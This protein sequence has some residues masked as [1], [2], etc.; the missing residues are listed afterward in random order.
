MKIKLNEPERKTLG[1]TWQLTCR[2]EADSYAHL[3][4]QN[5]QHHGS[6]FTVPKRFTVFFLFPK[7]AR[8]RALCTLQWYLDNNPAC[9]RRRF[10]FFNTDWLNSSV[11]QRVPRG[12]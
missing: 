1:R 3:D 12:Q 8:S 4:K 11:S 10:F 5:E 6:I 9:L 7:A 2:Q